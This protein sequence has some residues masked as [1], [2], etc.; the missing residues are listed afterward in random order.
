MYQPARLLELCNLNGVEDFAQAVLFPP[1][2]R[3]FE[4]FESFVWDKA[5]RAQKA[6]HGFIVMASLF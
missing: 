2:F 6:Q 5:A 3:V 1:V 4:L